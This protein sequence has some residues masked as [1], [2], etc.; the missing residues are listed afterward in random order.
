MRSAFGTAGRSPSSPL[1]SPIRT[2][3]LPRLKRLIAE[4]GGFEL[5][6][7]EYFRFRRTAPLGRLIL[8][9]RE[10]HYSTFSLYNEEEFDEALERFEENLA[11]RF[12]DMARITWYD[13]NVMF[14]VRKITIP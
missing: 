7:V 13:E 9:A 1:G 4:S 12:E 11:G 8:Q 6:E 14:V 10:N 3:R 2:P 5:E